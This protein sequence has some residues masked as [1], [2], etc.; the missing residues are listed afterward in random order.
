MKEIVRNISSLNVF[1]AAAA[2][3]T[4]M[5]AFC[6]RWLGGWVGGWLGGWVGGS[7]YLLCYG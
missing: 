4:S 2:P 5:F 1:G 3:N 6:G 7:F